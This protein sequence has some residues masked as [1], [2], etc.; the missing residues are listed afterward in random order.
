MKNKIL[1]LKETFVKL[2]YILNRKQQ[3]R[4]LFILM[5]I[6]VGAI[7]ETIGISLML[8]FIQMLTS[9]DSISDRWYIQLFKEVF[10]ISSNYLIII[11]LGFMIICVFVIKN[12][13]LIW[14]S[15]I[16]IKFRCEIIRDLSVHI[17]ES[18]MSRPY[19][20]FVENNSA[21]FMRSINDDVVAVFFV[22]DYFFK[23]I[24]NFFM[25]F[26]IMLF[27]IITEPFISMAALILAGGMILIIQS[28]LG[29]K[30]KKYRV[31][32]R[33]ANKEQYNT[34][35]QAI[36][37]V[38]DIKVMQRNAYFIER[39]RET[40]NK[41]IEADFAFGFTEAIPSR[42]IE[43]VCVIGIFVI[44]FCRIGQGIDTV[45]FIPKLSVFAMA[46]FK[47]MP[48]INSLINSLNGIAFKKIGLDATYNTMCAVAEYDR[49]QNKKNNR[50]KD[51]Q[52]C[53]NDKI[54]V[55]EV[56]WSYK[57]D[58]SIILNNVN[59]EIK[60]G[61]AVAFIGASGSGKTTLADIILGLFQPEIGEIRVDGCKINDWKQMIGYVSQT[62]FLI[63]D[64]IK[65]N[66]LF[67]LEKD[68]SEEE[69]WSILEMVQLKEYVLSLPLQLDTRIGERGVMLS[70]GQRQRI[71]IARTLI[72]NPEIIVLDEATSALDNE[73]E[74]AVMNAIEEL[75]GEKTLIIIAHRLSTIEKCD[76][77][78][79]IVDG[80]AVQRNKEDV[81]N[82]K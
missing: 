27:M 74:K 70:G 33:E 40:Y 1:A 4:S 57:K 2:K 60:K 43:S 41:K 48:M 53:F 39:Y 68:V 63:D 54:S 62:V 50:I 34:A 16:Q 23:I 28:F 76:R 14:S 47:I 25:L 77:I 36:S 72:Y 44:L 15:K 11:L 46:I 20:F 22:I 17:F 64:T 73:T 51:K 7:L 13:F 8:P 67:G 82:I 56:K 30:L 80:K 42:I 5:T 3:K 31:Q 58:S 65:N 19:K 78:Y 10:H 21:E 81:L 18:Y 32:L 59:L 35:Y 52:I 66:I 24:Q 9:I 71:A 61:E 26:F 37:G 29:N 55:S 75:Y 38:K 79:E 49:Q 6:I 69:I 12:V 45:E